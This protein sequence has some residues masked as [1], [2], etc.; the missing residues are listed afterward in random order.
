MTERIDASTLDLQE[1]LVEI[2]RVAKVVKG[3]RTFRFSALMVV[4]LAAAQE[5]R[6]K[7]RMRSERVS[8]TRKR[9]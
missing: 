5:K 2:N 7:S 4:T 3:G 9:T 1:K 8:R 6:L